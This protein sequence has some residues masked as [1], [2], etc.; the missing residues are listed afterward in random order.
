[1]NSLSAKA[2]LVS[3]SAISIDATSLAPELG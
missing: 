2:E 1:M 3:V